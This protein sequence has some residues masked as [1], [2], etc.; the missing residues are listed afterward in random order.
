[1]IHISGLDLVS[2]KGQPAPCSRRID[3]SGRYARICQSEPS[4]FHASRFTFHASRFTHH[5]SRITF[6]ENLS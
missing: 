2:A 6:Q 1:M 3:K 5:A 4:L